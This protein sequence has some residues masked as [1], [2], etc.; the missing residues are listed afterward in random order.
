MEP[1]TQQT[2]TSE[3]PPSAA[4][5]LYP[6]GYRF[7]P[8]DS[9]LILYYLKKKVDNEPIPISDIKDT[10]L[11]HNSPKT[12]TETFPKIGDNEW[13]FFTPRDRKYPN[14]SRPDRA[15]DTGYWKATGADKQVVFEGRV[16]GFRKALVFYQ[17]KAQQGVK[18]GWIMHE[19]RLNQSPR[20][21]RNPRD[22]RLDDWVLCRIYEKPL[23][24]PNANCRRG[25]RK[26]R[27]CDRDRVRVDDEEIKTNPL[28][29]VEENDDEITATN[30]HANVVDDHDHNALSPP[31]INHHHLSTP[32]AATGFIIK[33]CSIIKICRFLT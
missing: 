29:D 2:P 11:K 3:A 17:G 15:A 30:H 20:N 6:P 10:N 25:N 21:K 12:L 31:L 5:S 24:S 22:M 18:T 32:A 26:G 14:G 16:I 9:E 1:A 27:G 19:F 28:E 8:T 7:V 23:K 33:I 4:K 13:Y